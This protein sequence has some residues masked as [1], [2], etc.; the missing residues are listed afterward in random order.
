[1]DIAQVALFIIIILLAILLIVLGVQVFF[2]LR[3]FRKTVAKTNKVLDNTGV[4]T[5]SVS[6][7]ISSLSGIAAGIKTAAP[8]LNFFKKLIV[9]DEDSG[10]KNKKD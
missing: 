4:I 5:E 3:E 2:I 6:A 9:K 10:G 8:I 7:P 1:M